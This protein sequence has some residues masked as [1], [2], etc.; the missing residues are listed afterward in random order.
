MACSAFVASGDASMVTGHMLVADGG[1]AVLDAST[2][3]FDVQRVFDE[4][5]GAS[6]DHP[7]GPLAGLKVVELAAVGPG[8][9]A[10]M[11][12]ADL[13]ADVVRID[14]P[15][16]EQLVRL[17][18]AEEPLPDRSDKRAWPELA[19]RLKQAFLTRPHDEWAKIFT[20][21]TPVLP[22]GEA[23]QHPQFAERGSIVHAHGAYQAA[24]AP[25]L[26]ATPAALPGPLQ[27]P[28]PVDEVLADWAVRADG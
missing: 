22:C 26:S 15:G 1:G 5:Q 9:H 27:D 2:T 12:F 23:P 8:P 20:C 19:A 28:V 24:P 17:G 3:S 7:Q 18:L 4:L 11:F 13:G 6:M 10:A 21:T 14:R 25:R 16:G